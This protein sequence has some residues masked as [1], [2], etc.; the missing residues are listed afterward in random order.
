MTRSLTAIAPEHLARDLAEAGFAAPY[1]AARGFVMDAT[2]KTVLPIGPTPWAPG[3]RLQLSEMLARVLTGLAQ[4]AAVSN[5]F[6]PEY[7]A[8]VNIESRARYPLPGGLSDA[9]E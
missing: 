9:A 4:E 3:L 1:S 2:G 6:D 5:P 8:V 7:R